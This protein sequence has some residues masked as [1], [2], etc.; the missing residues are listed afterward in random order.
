[1]ARRMLDLIILGDGPAAAAA[2]AEAGLRGLDA[3]RP[4]GPV[5]SVTAG[6]RVDALA[7]AGPVVL[8]ASSVLT[9]AGRRVQPCGGTVPEWDVPR[10][11]RARMQ[12]DP[13]R[14]AWM[15][16][17]DA[18]GRTSV[19]G[20]LAIDEEGEARAAIHAIGTCVD[21]TGS[22]VAAWV[23]AVEPGRTASVTADIVCPCEGVTAAAI[24]AAVRDG[25]RDMN[26][27][28]AF[29]RCGMG[30][31]QGRLCEEVAAGVLAPFV[32]GRAAAGQWTMRPPLIP[33]PLDV[34]MGTFGYADIPVPPPAPL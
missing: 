10:L 24:Q 26:Q 18:A 15:P 32:G 22:Q 7:P 19:P 14:D 30:V 2:L 31:C 20:L 23:P 16:L 13:S 28:R 8:Y 4:A 9:V 11:L 1:M 27:L 21:C 29:T 5:W 12:F 6:F 3:L 33:V 25:A 17:R 34:L